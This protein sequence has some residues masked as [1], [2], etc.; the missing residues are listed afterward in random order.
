VKQP[1]IRGLGDT[2]RVI[3]WPNLRQVE[4]FAKTAAATSAPSAASSV[5]AEPKIGA[6]PVLEDRYPE[7]RASF[8][9]GV[10]TQGR[11]HRAG[12]IGPGP[13]TR[14]ARGG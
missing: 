2:T 6:Q 10:E 1:Q 4:F 12:A 5:R 14:Y 8:P 11:R 7:R 3:S 13:S 9:D